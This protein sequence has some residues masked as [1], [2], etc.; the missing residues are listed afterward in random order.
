MSSH[1]PPEKEQ[2]SWTT[3]RTPPTSTPRWHTLSPPSGTLFDRHSDGKEKTLRQRLMTTRDEFHP[4][5]EAAIG[6]FSARL[7]PIAMGG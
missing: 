4:E 1:P 5:M 3:S 7:Y 6:D 2:Y